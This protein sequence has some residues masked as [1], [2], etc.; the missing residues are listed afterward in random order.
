MEEL[1]L[2]VWRFL[3]ETEYMDTNAVVSQWNLQC[4]KTVRARALVVLDDVWSLSVLEQ[5]NFR[6]PGCKTLVVSR[7]KFPTVVNESYEVELLNN[8][9]AM[10]LFCN[11]AFGQNSVPFCADEP[12]V[13]QVMFQFFCY[14][15]SF[16]HFSVCSLCCS[17][18]FSAIGLLLACQ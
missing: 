8:T 18:H 3:S 9:E 7:S 5:L 10:A 16:V 1:K 17:L 2:R 12:L 6:V 4:E 14:L 13:Q 15:K 11:S